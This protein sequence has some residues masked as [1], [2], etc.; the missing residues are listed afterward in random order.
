VTE[1]QAGKYS[2]TTVSTTYGDATFLGFPN[3]VPFD[4]TTFDTSD[5]CVGDSIYYGG[6]C[7]YEGTIDNYTFTCEQ[8][9]IELLDCVMEITSSGTG[10]V[11][12]GTAI[13]D[14]LIVQKFVGAQCSGACTTEVTTTSIRIGEPDCERKMPGGGFL[15][16]LPDL[17]Q[18]P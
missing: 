5:V 4:T 9:D 18:R 16:R 3:C 14:L 6:M 8:P 11:E 1:E 17:L 2:S 10:R 12:S 13:V 15:G 7:S